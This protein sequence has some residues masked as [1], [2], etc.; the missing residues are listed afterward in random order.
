MVTILFITFDVPVWL[1]AG[2]R[3]ADFPG[4]YFFLGNRTQQFHQVGNAVPP[5]FGS[6]DCRCC[7]P[8]RSKRKKTR[9]E[10]LTHHHQARQGALFCRTHSKAEMLRPRPV[11]WSRLCEGWSCNT[12]TALS[13]TIDNNVAAG[14]S[15]VRIE[16]VW[17][18]RQSRITCLDSG[19]GISLPD[20]IWP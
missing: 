1:F 17:R 2:L 12:Q 15:E 10:F 13:D 20:L 19:A 4:N 16:F 14:A 5:L 18:T 11:Q 9:S 7:C 8:D 3:T 6:A